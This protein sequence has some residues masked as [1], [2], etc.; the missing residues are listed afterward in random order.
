MPK[1]TPN[2]RIACKTHKS[3]FFVKFGGMTYRHTFPVMSFFKDF[4]YHKCGQA[5]WE[6]RLK[7]IINPSEKTKVMV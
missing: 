3:E 7:L 4:G 1:F 5:L 2:F 6:E